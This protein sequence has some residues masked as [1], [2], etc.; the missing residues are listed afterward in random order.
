M[1][2]R[3]SVLALL[4]ITALL[5]LVPPG[6]VRSEGMPRPCV[7]NHT[8]APTGFWNWPAR[9]EVNVYLRTPDFSVDYASAAM[10]SILN[11]NRSSIENGS[12][13]HFIFRGL[14]EELHAGHGDLTIIR[15][16]V[17]NKKE[18]H[19]ALIQAHSLRG[20]QSIDYALVIVDARVVEPKVLTNV[21]TH[22]LGHSLGLLDCYRCAT[23]STAMGLMKSASESNG[24]D[25][26][27]ACDIIAVQTVYRELA[28]RSRRSAALS[29]EKKIDKGEEPEADD[30]PIIKP[31]R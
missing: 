29:D 15:G 7:V 28:A 17:F 3:F 9:S 4:T 11:W 30:T 14:T 22:E 26:P 25:G 5:S 23:E 10:L 16:D 12:D 13:V 8:Q 21:I 19:L 1:K 20:D 24:I 18:K 2:Y 6:R 27:T 31:P